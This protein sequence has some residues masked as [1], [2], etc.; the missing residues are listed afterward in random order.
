M[1]TA[2]VWSLIIKLSIPAILAQIVNLLYNIVDRI[3]IGHIEGNGAEALAGV[4]LTTSVIMLIAAFS[5]LVGG[6]IFSNAVFFT[7]FIETN[8][9]ASLK[10][11]HHNHVLLHLADS[12]C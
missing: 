7:R 4:G 10:A 11:I 8:C 3:Y 2:P 12:H 6:L 5:S 1:A 9:C